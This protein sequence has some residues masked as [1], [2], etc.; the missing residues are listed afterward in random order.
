MPAAPRTDSLWTRTFALL[1]LAEFLGYAQHFVLQPALPLYITQLGGSP[2]IVG[3]A[4]AANGVTSV[5]SRPIVGYWVDRWRATGMMIIGMIVQGLSIFFCFLP[6]NAAVIFANALRGIGWSSMAAS[7]YTLLASSA[8]PE[9]RGEAS[10]YFGGVQSSATIVFPALSLWLLGAA[11]GGFYL[12]FSFATLLVLGG[13]ATAWALA[14]ATAAQP[15]GANLAG[16]EPWWREIANVV[17]R[18]ILAAASLIFALNMSL[19]CLSSFVVLYARELGVSHFGWY[20]VA[21]G[22]TSALGRPLLGRLSDKLGAGR[23]L[24]IAFALETTALATMPLATNLTGLVM[25]GALWYTGA[26][27]GG[28]R[29]MALAIASAPAERRGRAMASYSTALPLSN[30]L[31]ALISGIIVDAAGYKSMYSV[32]AALCSLGFILIWKQWPRLK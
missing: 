29:I 17:D 21:V 18:P 23:S 14:R 32:A 25:S 27:I 8:P 3:I 13:A 19:P 5:V 10:G 20:Y 28:A 4:I 6:F 22:I 30:G 9:R 7:G 16:G 2:F 15:R 24:I 26:A 31:G 1:C 12:V 11:F